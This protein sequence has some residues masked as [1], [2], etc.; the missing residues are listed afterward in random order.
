MDSAPSALLAGLFDYAGLFPPAALPMEKA[1]RDYAGYRQGPERRALNRV[2]VPARRLTEFGTLLHGLPRDLRGP[3]PWRV[4][5]IAGDDLPADLRSV[6]EFTTR[7]GPSLAW[8]ESL[9]A[10]ARIPSQVARAREAVPSGPGLILELPLD[11]DLPALVHAVKAARARAKIRTGGRRAAD[12][13]TPDAVLGF[14]EV[15]AR[16]HVPF[17]ATAGLH[18]PVRGLAPLGYEPD[19]ER[20]TMLGYLNVLLAAIALWHGRGLAEARRLLEDE[21]RDAFQLRQ[22]EIAWRSLHFTTAE[23]AEARRLFATTVGSCSFTEPLE[24]LRELGA[25]IAGLP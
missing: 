15:C 9:E 12:I 14:L 22:D 25:G 19:A 8:I 2:V 7:H 18:H 3:G 20:V 24:E 16:E 1:L 17:K 23:I 6:R 21:D 11:A 5:A 13:P 4:T 10:T